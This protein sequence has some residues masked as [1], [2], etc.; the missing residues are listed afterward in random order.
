MKVDLMYT[1]YVLQI[2][3][4][5]APYIEICIATFSRSKFKLWTGEVS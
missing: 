5:L 4:R 1:Y 3:G 2:E